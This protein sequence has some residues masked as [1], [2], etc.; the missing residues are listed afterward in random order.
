[1]IR[2]GAMME[3]TYNRRVILAA[4]CLIN[5]CIGSIYAWSVFAA[6]MAARLGLATGDFAIVFIV[7]NG[8]GPITMIFGGRITEIIGAGKVILIGGRMFSRGIILSGFSSSVGLSLIPISEPTQ[9]F[10]I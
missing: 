3:K 4:S 6:P 7:A 2:K 9:P 8:V 1:M 10:Y 5:L